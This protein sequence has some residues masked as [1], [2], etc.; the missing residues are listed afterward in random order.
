MNIF[1]LA[2]DAKTAA[3]FH[4]DKHVVK[5]ILESAQLLTCAHWMTDM[6]RLP[7]NAYRKTHPNHPCAIWTRESLDNYRWLC[8]LAVA[9]CA[10]YTYRYGKIHKTQSHIEWL[11]ANPPPL[12]SVGI[13]LIRQ[14]MPDVY[15]RPNP[16]EAYRAYYLGAKTRM[17]RYT[18][19]PIPPFVA[20]NCPDTP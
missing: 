2:F 18:K 8:E 20:G 10:E 13:T 14:A 7:E 1:I 6:T 9:L 15:K 5:M 4:C 16:V 17:L 11:S 3:Q 19:R 12:P